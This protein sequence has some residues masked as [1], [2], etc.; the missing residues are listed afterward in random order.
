M[1]KLSHIEIRKIWL[2]YFSKKG[3]K[4]IDSASLIPHND[5]S[6][7]WINAGVAPLKKYFDGSVVPNNKRLCNIQKCIRTN[8]IENVGVTKRHQTFFEMM[9]NFSIG[10][11]F[12]N[13]AIEFAWE[14]LT[15]EEYFD[16]PK[17]KLYV[18]IYTDDNESYDKWISVGMAPLHI[19]RLEENF[20]EIGEGP[21]GPDSEIFFD[22]GAKYDKDGTAFEKFSKDEEQERYV[23]IWNLVFSQYNA[24]PGVKRKDYKELPHKNID[25]GAG[26]ERWCLMFQDVDSNFETD[27]F[28]PIIEHI[29][30]LT[31]IMYNSQKEFKIIADHVRTITFALADGASFANT[32]RGY[33]IRRLL[34]RSVRAG[35]N[36]GIRDIFMYKLI[37]TV[38]K[39]MKEAYPYL[40]KKITIIETKIITE[41]KLFSKTIASGETI[42]KEM[43][44]N[45][46]N[47]G[48]LS[49]ADAFKLYDTYGFPY[50]LTL[51]YLEELGYTTKREDFD[52]YMESQ[53]KLAKTSGT[54]KQSMASQKKVLLDFTEK[55]DFN[56][57]I[58]RLKTT[59]AA[60]F[61]KETL[62]SKLEHD[63]YIALKRTCLYATGGGEVSDTGMI[64][65]NT[66]KA[67]VVDVFKGPNGQNI[68]KVKLLDGTI[69]VGD[70]CE[71]VVDKIRRKE[72]EVNH[73]T[74]HILHYVLRTLIDKDI[75][76]AGSYVDNEKLRLD[77]TYSGKLSDEDV[78]K[79]EDAVN[80]MISK[81]I[82]VSTEVMPID[83]AKKLGAMALF[84]EKYSDIVRVVKIGKSIE[85]CGGCHTNNTSNIK[86][87]AILKLENKGS[88]TYRI[89]AATNSR[90]NSALFDIIKPYNDEM[91]KL[92]MKAK[93]IIDNAA[94]LGM[95]LNFDVEINNDK[96]ESYEDIVYNQNELSYVRDEVKNLVK[97]FNRLNSENILNN[98]DEY[99]NS[100][101]TYNNINYLIKD[102]NDMDISIL[103]TIA[104][105]LINEYDNLFVFL[106]N[107]KENSSLNFIA[108]SNSSINAGYIVKSVS[109]FANGN[110]GGSPTF[111]QGGARD[112]DKLEEIKNFIV[113][114]INNAK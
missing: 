110:G 111:A 65:G 112:I 31:G 101:K 21:C 26:L 41:E 52:K 66:F 95:K 81:N 45:I 90:V 53:K 100:I 96:P 54:T 80:K 19:I 92:L 39:S 5:D 109:V 68:H 30:D 1:K 9:G 6:L 11:Y 113:S 24:K 105:S 107:I 43:V 13:E 48:V 2:D 3:H 56:Y 17:D 37:G 63:G 15:S 88:D 29:E 47:D 27:L 94:S 62:E 64:I 70:T 61:S 59:V 18:T 4:I 93:E 72:I 55:C 38:V 77:F 42:L 40:E 12:R 67:R 71:V 85:L 91:I 35:R 22:R 106:I 97:E 76:Q 14:L 60:I 104:D 10:D 36:L 78:I 7:L 103:K 25:T 74:V 84:T 44:K 20:W 69:N 89:E 32:G 102:V 73:S 108:K 58:Y 82:I 98:L 79:V 28:K 33:V 114:E 23:E 86:K 51:E 46:G 57:G 99:R 49:G 8:D 83:K 16:I 75:R 87:F 34:R 50:E